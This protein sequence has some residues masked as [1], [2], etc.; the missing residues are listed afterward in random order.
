MISENIRTGQNYPWE[1]TCIPGT[2][3]SNR[4]DYPEDS[5]DDNRSYR[6]QQ[7]PNERERPPNERRYPNKDRRPPRRGGS[8]DNGRPPDR[9]GGPPDRHGGPLM[10]EDP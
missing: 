8:Q 10:E 7:H 6:G 2:S 9:H 5:S 1:G 3:T 4:R